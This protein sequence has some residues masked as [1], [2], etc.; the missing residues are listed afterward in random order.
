MVMGLNLKS[1]VLCKCKLRDCNVSLNMKSRVLRKCTRED[2]GDE[3]YKLRAI[4]LFVYYCRLFQLKSV[5]DMIL[6]ELKK[7]LV[8]YLLPWHIILVEL[9]NLP[10]TVSVA[11]LSILFVFCWTI[12][13][14]NQFIATQQ[15]SPMEEII[16]NE[17]LITE[18]K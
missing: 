6:K 2:G 18:Y 15:S 14:L 17:L 8:V 7:I 16:G 1:R 9:L 4:S 13:S 10:I 3:A 11:C 12:L 5:L